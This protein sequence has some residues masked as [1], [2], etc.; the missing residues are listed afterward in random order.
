MQSI[1]YCVSTRA[2]ITLV[3]ST[4]QFIKNS[5][6]WLACVA[7]VLLFVQNIHIMLLLSHATLAPILTFSFDPKQILLAVVHHYTEHIY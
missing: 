7:A 6:N 2:C 3:A 4:V 5:F 1:S